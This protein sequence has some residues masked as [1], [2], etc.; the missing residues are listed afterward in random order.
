MAKAKA[1]IST[2]PGMKWT[3]NLPRDNCPLEPEEQTAPSSSGYCAPSNCTKP[4]AAAGLTG[5]LALPHEASMH[6]LSPGTCAPE[7]NS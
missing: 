2:G 5:E 1:R 4:A 6:R 7:A 3:C